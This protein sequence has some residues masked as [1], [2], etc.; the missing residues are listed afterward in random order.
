MTRS[1]FTGD[2]IFARFIR[3]FDGAIFSKLGYADKSY[4][5]AYDAST[6]SFRGWSLNTSRCVQIHY[7]DVI[8]SPMA[9]KITSH[10]IIYSTFYSGPDQS[11]HQSSASLAFVWGIHRS[12]HK[13]P[14][15]RKMFSFDDV[16]LHWW[17]TN[18]KFLILELMHNI[19]KQHLPNIIWVELSIILATLLTVYSL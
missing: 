19:Q 12:P 18:Y 1:P 9:S 15:M 11:K 2:T 13:G 17:N 10:T 4:I 7:D 3:R 16:I 5:L 8:M 6:G 14:V